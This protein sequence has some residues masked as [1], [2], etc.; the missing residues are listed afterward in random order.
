MLVA[1]LVGVA[2]VVAGC[3][4]DS[5]AGVAAPGSAP[6]RA[7]AFSRCMRSHGVPNFPDPTGAGTIPKLTLP[8]LGVGD[9]QFQTAQ[10]A[11]RSLIPNGGQPTQ[12]ALQQSWSDDRTF[13]RCMRS[14]GVPSWPDPTRYS[15]H[16]DRP[17]FD[18]QAA[19]VDP[20]APQIATRIRECEPLLHGNNPQH[21][22]EAGP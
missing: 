17:T 5:T 13:A 12:A 11:C 18:L 19:A 8:Q 10:T 9:A 15:R 14:H 3:G 16:P 7:L 4:G 21:L 2:V 6:D 20:N 22:G 1:V